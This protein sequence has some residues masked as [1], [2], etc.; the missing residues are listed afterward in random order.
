M[1]ERILNFSIER[2]FLV[3]LVTSVLGL[4]GVYALTRLPIM[5][6]RAEGGTSSI[7]P[8]RRHDGAF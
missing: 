6:S 7:P 2:R 1:L 5:R 8:T 4:I 3:V